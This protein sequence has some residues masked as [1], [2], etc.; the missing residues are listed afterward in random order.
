[1]LD[2]C[3]E[4][5]RDIEHQYKDDNVKFC[6]RQ[7]E[8]QA[9]EF[10]IRKM[11]ELINQMIFDTFTIEFNGT[12]TD[13]EESELKHLALI[14]NFQTINIEAKPKTKICSIPKAVTQ[15]PISNLSK[16]IKEQSTII[17]SS[18]S[19]FYKKSVLQASIEIHIISEQFLNQK[20]QIARMIFVFFLHSFHLDGYYRFVIEDRR[21][22][23]RVWH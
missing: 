17:L 11:K 22:Q 10:L 12:L 14:N 8:F 23:R 20:V 1:M 16:F 15:N 19:I 6:V 13:T 9:P 3:S 5:L 4:K 18:E 2:E 21:D 7:N